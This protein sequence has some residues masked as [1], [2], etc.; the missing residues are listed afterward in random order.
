MDKFFNYINFAQYFLCF[1]F[2]VLSLRLYEE[3][4]GGSR[5]RQL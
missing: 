1:I 4:K 2:L 5:T 3:I